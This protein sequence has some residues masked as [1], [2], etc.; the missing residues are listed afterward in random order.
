MRKMSH[1]PHVWESP[2]AAWFELDLPSIRQYA[3]FHEAVSALIQ[4]AN[5]RAILN[6]VTTPEYELAQA[7]ESACREALGTLVDAWTAIRVLDTVKMQGRG[8]E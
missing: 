6:D 4:A 1:K 8:S 2:P 5:R 7:V 3:P